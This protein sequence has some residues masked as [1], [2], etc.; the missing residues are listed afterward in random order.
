MYTYSK[1]KHCFQILVRSVIVFLYTLLPVDSLCGQA[2][3]KSLILGK[4][5][6]HAS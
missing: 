2:K 4:D 5:T 3:Q 1:Q 6:N